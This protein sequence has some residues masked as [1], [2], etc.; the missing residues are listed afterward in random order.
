VY[1]A[2]EA[3]VRPLRNM[4][5]V[6]TVASERDAGA[7]AATSS[8]PF[9]PIDSGSLQQSFAP[10][11]RAGDAAAADEF[12]ALARRV[13][14]ALAKIAPLSAVEGLSARFGALES[15]ISGALGELAAR[16]DGEGSG[17][18][19]R[20][21]DELAGHMTRTEE[22]LARLDQ[23]EAE[24]QTLSQRLSDEQVVALFGGLVPTAD[25]L[26]QFAEDAATRSAN[27][28]L[29]AFVGQQAAEGAG[30]SAGGTSGA[31]L[32]ALSEM[33]ATFMDD[34][35]RTDA[36]TIEALETLQLAMQQLLDRVDAIEVGGGAAALPQPEAPP[37]MTADPHLVRPAQERPSRLVGAP[38]DD[39]EMRRHPD[40]V[41]EEQIGQA[42][43]SWRDARDAAGHRDR[44]QELPGNPRASGAPEPRPSRSGRV[45]AN[46]DAPETMPDRSAP[47]GPM[48]HRAFREL[49][50]KASERGP[51]AEKAKGSE[52]SAA[53]LVERLMT[54]V[55]RKPAAAVA[56]EASKVE[57]PVAPAAA[58]SPAPAAAARVR[59]AV[60]A[61]AAAAILVL[62]GY[63]Y[64][65]G[66]RNGLRN[67]LPISMEQSEP[68]SRPGRA[69]AGANGTATGAGPGIDAGSA[70][71]PS[72]EAPAEGQ[73]GGAS[74]TADTEA[75][76]RGPLLQDALIHG[77][78]VDQSAAGIAISTGRR[79]SP[80]AVMRARER[81]RLA[82]LSQ[83]AADQA[84]AS[85]AAR[86]ASMV[87][88]TGAIETA[89][90]PQLAQSDDSPA[91]PARSSGP[92]AGVVTGALPGAPAATALPD[93]RQSLELPPAPIGPLSLRI[94]AAKGD[95]AAQL[96][97]AARFA[98]GQGVKRSF[99]DAADWYERA[100]NQGLAVAQY[101]I[102]TLYE[103]GLGVTADSERARLWYQRAAAQG[104]VKAMHNL[105]VMLAS[106]PS[107]APDYQMAAHLFTEAAS[108]GLADSQFNLAVLTESGQG[109]ARDLGKALQW[110][111]LAARGGDKEAAKRRDQ[112]IAKLPTA[113]LQAAEKKVSDWRAKPV[114]SKAN[115]LKVAGAAWKNRASAD[116]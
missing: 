58:A 112:L 73:T 60:V 95:P 59:P 94:A 41:L 105:A 88:A 116:R 55:K 10:R 90:G 42:T 29:E 107:G 102:A 85:Q 43:G 115:E 101:R 7:A 19:A 78:P 66:P 65:G 14:A 63:W 25:E 110:Y 79:A 32:R 100:A 114:D 71:S 13:E 21:L 27:R 109:V 45:A 86:A 54:M 9:A 57:A 36:G 61:V 1:E 87:G 46:L 18:I 37:A 108:R 113:V 49:A 89:G 64:F 6:M 93:G 104:N 67:F 80:D 70:A 111:S 20:H 48:D 24:L 22:R 5:D 76:E 56:P 34:R 30:R 72:P 3:S 81:A 8:G 17:V 40:P 83:R 38:A 62:A 75:E 16:A 68:A 98:E 103:R 4:L 82:D 47:A 96:E 44:A 77:G 92:D 51:A 106:P 15:R 52:S 39:H 53:G 28:A 26:T 35:R 50:R 12:A 2:S 99:V 69:S 97:I 74:R 84:A 11:P 23:I 91:S 31:E 33:L